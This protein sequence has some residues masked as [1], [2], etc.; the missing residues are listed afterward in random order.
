FVDDE[1]AVREMARA[2]LERLNFQSLIATDGADGLM[3]ATEYRAELRAIVT[4][5]H[6]PHM[7]GLV[8]VRAL[9]RMLP[10]IPVVVASGRMEEAMA[11][12]FQSLGVV[13][14]LDKPFTEF[15]LAEA[16]RTL[17][18]PQ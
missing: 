12:E 18:A 4:D 10:D 2:V 14:R 3:Q 16:L 17:L 8:F 5:L 15:Q 6:M 13:N 7:D 1:A 9:R 11:A